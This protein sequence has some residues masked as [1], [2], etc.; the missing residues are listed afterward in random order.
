MFGVG[1][2]SGFREQREGLMGS[3][4]YDIGDAY[5]GSGEEVERG[6]VERL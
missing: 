2:G 4:V 5:P 3:S 1:L 6:R